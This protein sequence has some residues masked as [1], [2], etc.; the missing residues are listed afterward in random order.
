MKFKLDENLPAE[1]AADLRRAGNDAQTVHQ[2]AL[3][4]TT[5]AELL[6]HA[7]QESRVLLSL[8]RGLGNINRHPPGDYSG[9]VI[10]RPKQEGRSHLREFVRRRLPEIEELPLK[11]RLVI[12]T[13]TGL[14]F[15]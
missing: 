4:G 8:D 7:H 1:I 13:P 14:R 9:I 15:R 3:A 6:L 11:G 5:D 10:L 12:V 2:E